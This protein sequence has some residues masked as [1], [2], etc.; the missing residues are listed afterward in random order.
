MALFTGE[1]DRFLQLSMDHRLINIIGRFG[2]GKTL[3]SV[4]ICEALIE[5]K[6][7]DGCLAN[8]GVDLP[9]L[10]WREWLPEGDGRPARH[11]GCEGAVYLLDEA[12]TVLDNRTSILNPQGLS[13]YVRKL[14]MVIVLPSVTPI[15]KRFTGMQVLPSVKL[16]GRWKYDWM[17]ADAAGR[18]QESGSFWLMNP[19]SYY[20]RFDSFGFPVDDCQ[21]LDLWEWTVAR[22]KYSAADKAAFFRSRGGGSVGFRGVGAVGA[23]GH[24]TRVR[25]I[26]APLAGLLGAD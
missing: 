19:G 15:D 3:L 1:W 5:A 4:A 14:R 9:A 12:G 17:L 20:G 8:I 26:N 13:R 16:A 24:S 10:N 23:G 6:L 25:S 18:L 2:S 11:R 21:L 7:V 22:R